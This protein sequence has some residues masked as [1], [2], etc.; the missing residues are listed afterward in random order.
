[1]SAFFLFPKQIAEARHPEDPIYVEYADNITEKFCSDMKRL[2]QIHYFGGGGGFLRNVEKIILNFQISQ[3]MNV[4]EAR[5]LI[6]NCEEDLLKRF[7]KDTKIRPYLNNYPFTE[8][9]IEFG[10]STDLQDS[11]PSKPIAM[12]FSANG[13][14]YYQSY[15]RKKRKFNDLH[16]ETYQEA[17]KLAN[18]TP[19]SNT[20]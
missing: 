20:K 18:I 4:P 1:M 17:L 15:D 12:V 19:P 13:S 3:P 14:I 9:N 16:E 8:K 6:I 10:I 7:N 5:S 2:Y 11:L